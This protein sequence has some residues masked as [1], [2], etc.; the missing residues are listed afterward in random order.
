MEGEIFGTDGVRGRALEGWLAEDAVEALGRAAALVLGGA[1][2]TERRALLAH[3]G[4]ASAAPLSSALARGFAHAGLGTASAGLLPTPGLAWLTTT[5]D[6]VAFGAMIS[7]SHNPAHD[8]GIKL[9]GPG[10]RKLT[11]DQQRAIEERIRPEL[12]NVR[13]GGPRADAEAHVDAALADAYATHLSEL[14]AGSGHRLDLSGM[15]VA[16]DCANGAASEV[17]PRVLRSLGADVDVLFGSPDG[18]NI[19]ADCGSTSP[20]RLREHVAGTSAAFGIALDGDADRCLLVDETGALVDGDAIMAILARDAADRGAWSDP[21]IVATVMSNR[22]LHRALEPKGIGV[23]E[24]GVGDR[25]VVE[26]LESE[27]LVLGGE[28]SGHI[29]FAEDGVFIGDGLLTAL[30]VLGVSARTGQPL[31]A[32]AAPFVPFPQVLLG[33]PVAAK[34]PLDTLAGFRELV[35]AFE[36]ELGNDGRVNVR[37]SGTEPKARVMVE[38]PDEARIRAMAEELVDKLRAEIGGA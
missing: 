13:L 37:Y 8:N 10:G 34:P 20:E 15:R 22:G 32:L 14:A 38:G 26:G 6:D 4:R 36:A 2:G 35:G 23:V 31:G 11:D 17:G 29:I 7:A 28:K 3:D 30:H 5:R 1:D 27:G 18:S 25:Q 33:L 21:R 19:N 24:V 16:I 9:F 12:E